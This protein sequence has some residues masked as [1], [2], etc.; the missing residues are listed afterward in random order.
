[1]INP[2]LYPITIEGVKFDVSYDDAN[3]NFDLVSKSKH[4]EVDAADLMSD[5]LSELRS[6]M[7][8]NYGDFDID[9]YLEKYFEDYCRR[10]V[11]NSN[12]QVA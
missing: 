12:L 6:A 5:C 9:A 8:C 7:G 1:M 3:E 11:K 2:N 10:F 4:I